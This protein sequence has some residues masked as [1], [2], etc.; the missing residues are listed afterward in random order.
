MSEAVKKALHINDPNVKQAEASDPLK[1]VW[2][3]A[4]A[5]TGK[6]KV[7]TDRVL[8]LML[9]RL[10]QD[11]AS[12]TAPHKI[13]CLTFT[14]TGAAEMADRIYKRLSEWSIK[15]DSDLKDELRNLIGGEPDAETEKEARKLFAKVL[16]TPGGLKIMTIHSF[17]QSVLKRFPIEA[18]VAPHFELMDEQ[19]AREYLTKCLH[20]IIAD[21]NNDPT[22]LLSQSFNL[23]TLHLDS[24]SMAKLMQEVMSKRAL[25]SKILKHH[26]GVENTITEM[27]NQLDVS[28]K[29]TEDSVLQELNK[30][31]NTKLKNVIEALEQGSATDKK[32]ALKISNWLTGNLS[33]DEYKFVYI[34]KTDGEIAKTLATKAVITAYPDTLDIMYEEAERLLVVIEKIKSI[35]L[36]KLNSALLNVTASMIN[37]YD[38]YKSYRD[39]LDYDDL[40][41]KTCDLLSDEKMV[42]WVLFKLDNG[43]DHILVDE[44]QDT[45]RNQWHIVKALSNEFFEAH[46]SKENILRTLFVVGDEKQ[47]IFSFQGADMQEFARMQNFF[48][49]KAYQIQ[50][51]WEVLLN[52]SFRS[53]S[54]V[55]EVVDNVFADEQTRK[56]V[57]AD[58]SRKVEHLA[59]RQGQAGLVEL[60]PIIK[61]DE[62]QK[63]EPWQLPSQ[64]D[65]GESSASK[66]ANKIS[67]TIKEWIDTKEVLVS[68][69]RPINAGD[70][71]ILVQSRKRAAFVELLMRALKSADI[72]VAGAD[73]I[74][75]MDE[76]AIIDILALAKFALL[77]RDD[78][79]LAA[80]LKS[81]LIGLSE[82][83]LYN[84]C[85]GRGKRA[86]WLEVRD[87]NPKLAD[88]LQRWINISGKATPYEFFAEILNTPCFADAVSG[89]RA[90]YSRL[91]FDIEDAI[92]EFLNECLNY[93]QS[94]TPSLQKFISWFEQST[95]EIKR[96]QESNDSGM[97]RIMTIHAAKGLQA[98]IVFLPD[99]T[100]DLKGHSSTRPKML[101]PKDKTGIPLWASR[102][103]FNNKHYV[104]LQTAAL[105]K[106]E[107]ESKRLLYVAM[108][109]AEDRL[110]I[111]GHGN[112]KDERNCWYNLIKR[113]FP[114]EAK[115][116]NFGL[117]E[118]DEP[119]AAKR[120]EYTQEV[121]PKEEPI[122]TTT[123]AATFTL[124]EWVFNKPAD[125]PLPPKPL[126]P[127][128]QEEEPAINSPLSAEDN[129]KYNRGNIVHKLLE[130]LPDISSYKW[131]EA[132][133]NY[134][135]RPAL[136]IPLIQQ[137][138]LTKELLAI[139]NHPEFAAIFGENSR[140]EVP[141][142][143]LLEANV[144]SGQIDR[145]VVT[146]TEVLIVDYK[147]NRNPPVNAANIPPVYIKQMH[148]YEGVIQSIYPNRIIKSALLWT[149]SL[150]LMPLN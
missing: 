127:S 27:Y 149:D 136:N 26:G 8:R 39:R 145:L 112:I 102:K 105:E 132:L 93:E 96:E 34:K 117:D 7:L 85:S 58:T 144:V 55:L 19:G 43:I 9:P 16:D 3:G 142:V 12:A 141:I 11:S 2:V 72:P 99:T 68:K 28:T 101:W 128:R 56:G 69:N 42:P 74:T 63:F 62:K 120:F 78:L 107:D 150:T 94:H 66:L 148:T 90:F 23:L 131:E 57:V 122:K 36:A 41:T 91:G 137:T 114:L 86:L 126:A 50:E 83:E 119:I 35:K 110:Y 67:S 44:A 118:N 31:T 97:V 15:N 84:L 21:T 82:D 89:K 47:S 116:I 1:S 135:S 32:K 104:N 46:G 54:A 123:K 79:T 143:G 100:Q 59:F 4:S 98:P 52:H 129:W 14:K 92:D 115:E 75:L 81:P 73:R 22:S 138:T 6:T 147:S 64:I 65:R 37:H 133:N 20:N 103:E 33:F 30:T 45:S 13:L 113:S 24:D 29:D 17:C 10:S 88:Y 40:I 146:K 134:L 124:P 53:T 111:C 38:T 87:K 130:L 95:A 108:T 121:A 51:G 48:G 139:L 61:P 71:L 49:D 18:G 125:E 76:I 109:R 140:A 106:T 60:W 77:P 5:G 25:L 70:I 80:L